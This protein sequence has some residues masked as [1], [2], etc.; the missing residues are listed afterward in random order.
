MY[1]SLRAALPEV[2]YVTILTDFATIPRTFG[3][4]RD[5]ISILCVALR[6][7]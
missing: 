5:K 2:P 4:R 3:W 6:R 7:P 1:Q